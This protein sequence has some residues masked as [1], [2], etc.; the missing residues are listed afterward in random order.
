MTSL[1]TFQHEI[2][3]ISHREVA[4]Q[5]A[6]A[7]HTVQDKE[8]SKKVP[9][10]VPSAVPEAVVVKDGPAAEIEGLSDKDEEIQ[11]CTLVLFIGG[12][13]TYSSPV[14][15]TLSDTVRL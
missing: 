14:P 1:R 2:D 5:R 10:A 9:A 4:K 3:E 15:T 8:N 11:V 12:R 6:A 13:I 7:T